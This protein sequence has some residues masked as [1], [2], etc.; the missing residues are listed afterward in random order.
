MNILIVVVIV[1]LA[2]FMIIK[3]IKKSLRGDCNCTSCGPNKKKICSEALKD[4][5]NRNK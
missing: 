5:R 2:I 3:N 1:F 4:S